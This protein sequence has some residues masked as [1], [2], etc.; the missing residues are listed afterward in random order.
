VPY[1]TTPEQRFLERLTRRAGAG[2]TM[3]FL[4]SLGKPT[5]LNR[6]SL[7]DSAEIIGS[8]NAPDN[9]SFY[10][11]DSSLLVQNDDGRFK[12]IEE[13]ANR[14]KNF[15]L[16]YFRFGAKALT[17]RNFFQRKNDEQTYSGLYAFFFQL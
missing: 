15:V 6:G 14:E 5:G 8:L 13:R 9:D 3:P 7:L 11:L 16:Q 10:F 1:G 17:I 12:M 2:M 4:S